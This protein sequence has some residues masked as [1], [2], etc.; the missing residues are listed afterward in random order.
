M[1]YTGK[2]TTDEEGTTISFAVN[3]TNK[4]LASVPEGTI[5]IE[6]LR[7]QMDKGA[8]DFTLCFLRILMF[9]VETSNGIMSNQVKHSP[10]IKETKRRKKRA[11]KKS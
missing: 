1:K 4:D 10:S 8:Y 5:S 9:E 3:V 11:K 7:K 2:V 6:E